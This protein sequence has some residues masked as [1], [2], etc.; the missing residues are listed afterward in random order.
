MKLLIVESPTKAKH[1]SHFLGRDWQVRASLGH[2]R[3]LTPKGEASYVRPPDFKMNY[4]IL[5][6]KHKEIVANL[7][8]AAASASDVY[9]ATDPD[10]EGEAISWHLAQVLGIKTSVAKRVTYQEVTE[11]AVLKA[12]ANP[13]NI[14]MKLVM[15]QECR[16]ALDRIVGWEVSGPLSNV[17][18]TKASAGRVQT[19]AV[20]IVVEREQA[21]RKFKSTAYFQIRAHFSG[22]W[23]AIWQDGLPDGTYFQDKAFADAL[24]AALPGMDL[25]VKRSESKIAFRPP[26]P[27]FTTSTLQMDGSRALKVSAEKIMMAAQALFEQGLITYHR[28]DSPNLSAEGQALLREAATAFSLPLISKPRQWKAKGDAQEAHEAIRPTDPMKK[29]AGEDLIQRDLYQ[30]IWRRSI[31]SQMPDAQYQNTA[32]LLDGGVF[33][34]KPALFKANGRKPMDP[35]WRALYEETKDEDDADAKKQN[36]QQKNPVPSLKIGSL[37]K[38]QKG[39]VVPKQTEPPSRFTEATLIA[40]LEKHGVGRPSTYVSIM[41]TIFHRGYV[42]RK[43]KSPAL[44]PTD[45]GEKIIGSLTPFAFADIDYTRSVEETLDSIAKGQAPARDLLL[46]TYDDIQSTLKQ[47]PAGQRNGK[48]VSGGLSCTV[49]GCNGFLHR[50]ESKKKKGV[51]FWACRG[52]EKHPLLKDKSGSPGEPFPPR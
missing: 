12:V 52:G 26:P 4:E 11:S 9:F 40:E 13:R 30:L 51:Y 18:N 32:A 20:R 49:D 37:I 24:A 28:T 8:K 7:K 10:R 36:E 23:F 31:A 5:D 50:M 17:L 27:P 16:R 3:D 29:E 46:K 43:G 25:T 6:D 14:N 44:H 45:L 19:P 39:E 48:S 1:I 15:A 22:G 41:R 33:Q 42:E 2:V 35:G 34:G 47:M 38:P 21:I